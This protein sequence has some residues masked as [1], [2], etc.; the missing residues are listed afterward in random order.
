M[1]QECVN[2]RFRMQ[3]YHPV[4]ECIFGMNDGMREKDVDHQ[5]T[6]PESIAAVTVVV[7]LPIDVG[8]GLWGWLAGWRT[9]SLRCGIVV[10]AI[11]LKGGC[12]C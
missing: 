2:E 12:C 4:D 11:W 8:N 6:G 7:D 5:I 9:A 10:A 3:G 1:G